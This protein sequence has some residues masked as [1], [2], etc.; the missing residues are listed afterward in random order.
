VMEYPGRLGEREKEGGRLRVSMGGACQSR[1]G[2]RA[3]TR[4]RETADREGMV[5][6]TWWVEPAI[7]QWW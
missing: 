5:S 1:P 7:G 2:T 4:E 6:S 3:R